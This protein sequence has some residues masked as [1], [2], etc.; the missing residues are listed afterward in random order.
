MLRET[1]GREELGNRLTGYF[2]SGSQSHF[3]HE[4][5]RHMKWGLAPFRKAGNEPVPFLTIQG[6]FSAL[7]AA[8]RLYSS[9]TNGTN[10]E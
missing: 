9:A 5:D 4:K 2:F 7:Q 10:F 6:Y 3:S 1:R 8:I